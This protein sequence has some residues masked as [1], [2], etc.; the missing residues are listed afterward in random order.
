MSQHSPDQL[1]DIARAQRLLIA[2]IGC[3][4]LLTAASFAINA[5]GDP[6]NPTPAQ[7]TMGIAIGAFSLVTV[8]I[9]MVGTYRLA[10]ALGSAM[11]WLWTVAMIVP[12]LS[13][14]LLLTLNHRATVAIRA[15]GVRVGLFG[16]RAEDVDRVGAAQPP[17]P[18]NPP[19]AS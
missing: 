17:P 19:P 9:Q 11:A 7:T 14:I 2:A 4:L 6:L 5:K 10:R 18:M 3:N 8:V 16:A 12:C 1:R 15:A 13:L